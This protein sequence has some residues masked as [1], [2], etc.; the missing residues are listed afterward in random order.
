[1]ELLRK[2]QF[3][4]NKSQRMKIILVWFKTFLSPKSTWFQSDWKSRRY[5]RCLTTWKKL[6]FHRSDKYR[7]FWF[8]V[9]FEELTSFYPGQSIVTLML[10]H[11]NSDS[12]LKKRRRRKRTQRS[13]C[14]PMQAIVT[15][16]VTYYATD[17][18]AAFIHSE[19][20]SSSENA[21]QERKS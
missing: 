11:Q 14:V 3:Y 12:P 21:I 2:A 17:C 1:M 19:G 9:F 4:L 20:S 5:L 16:S 10:G 8:W 6:S 7:G 18:I 13:S 15:S